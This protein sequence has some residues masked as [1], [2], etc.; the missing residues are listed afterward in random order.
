MHPVLLVSVLAC[1]LLGG[2]RRGMTVTHSSAPRASRPNTLVEGTFITGAGSWDYQQGNT[3]RQFSVTQSGSSLT[4]N[5]DVTTQSPGG[6]NSSSG[7]GSE[8]ALPA[9]ASAW[10]IYVESPERLWFFNG[11]DELHLQLADIQNTSSL[12]AIS[13]GKAGSEAARVPDELIP[14]LPEN[15]QKLLPKPPPPTTRPS[16]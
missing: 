2:C 3:S 7:T 1:L 16:I 8:M 12:P 5:L 11:K 6:G 14:R 13:G 9:G 10:F 4:W 15:L